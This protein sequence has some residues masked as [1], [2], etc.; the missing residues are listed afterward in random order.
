MR[1]KANKPNRGFRRSFR[2]GI[3]IILILSLLISWVTVSIVNKYSGPKERKTEEWKDVES[4]EGPDTIY[5][6]K[7]KEVKV[8]DTVYIRPTLPKPKAAEPVVLSR[9]TASK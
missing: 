5:V 4:E 2:A 3:I 8:R 9:D 6:E 7:I 1:N